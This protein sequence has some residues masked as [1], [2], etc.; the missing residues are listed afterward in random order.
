M[1][2]P[3]L[4]KTASL[5]ALVG[6]SL[7]LA[8]QGQQFG[9][10]AYSSDGSAITITMGVNRITN[11]WTYFSDPDWVSHPARFYRTRSR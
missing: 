7:P 6:W 8:T 5:A 4:L 2:K 10:F 3:T 9:D 11:G 1:K